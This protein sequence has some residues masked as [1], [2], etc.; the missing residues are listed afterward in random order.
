MPDPIWE[1]DCD[2]LES[3]IKDF[4]S[5][6]R[7]WPN[8]SSENEFKKFNP[9]ESW[10]YADYKYM[11]QLFEHDFD[12]LEASGRL[13]RIWVQRPKWKR[14]HFMDRQRRKRWILFP[15]NQSDH[16]RPTR[17]PYEES[18]VFSK[19]N[20]GNPQLNAYPDFQNTTP[21]VICLQP[22]DV[23]FVPRHW[24]HYVESLDTAVSVNTWIEMNEDDDSR[25]QEAISRLI[26]TSLAPNIIEQHDWLNPTEVVGLNKE[27]DKFVI[28]IFL[29]VNID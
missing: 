23:L 28:H 27:I 2:Y 25:L 19:L 20:V 7:L 3:T 1:G 8:V 4:S 26:I 16:L 21:Y 24:W 17:I 14:K 13:G 12:T 29:G 6:L 5:W 18:S 22:G 9:K 11:A 10:G 15:P